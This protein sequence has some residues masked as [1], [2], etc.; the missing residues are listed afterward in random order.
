MKDLS[1]Q[2][3][4]EAL[5]DV[6]TLKTDLGAM[7]RCLMEEMRKKIREEG[8]TKNIKKINFKRKEVNQ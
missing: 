3:L 2:E 8:K 1:L 6:E 4:E 7:S 5:G